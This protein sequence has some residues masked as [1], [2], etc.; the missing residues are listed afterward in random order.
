MYLE[1]VYGYVCVYVYIWVGRCGHMC[2]HICIWID[3]CGICVGMFVL[4]DGW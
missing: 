2:V 3:G 1:D 4:G